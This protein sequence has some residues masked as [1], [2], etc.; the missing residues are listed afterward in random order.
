MSISEEQINNWAEPISETEAEKCSNAIR[1]IG[2]TIKEKFGNSVKIIHQ[3]SHKN[4]T[5]IRADS[6]VD[7]AVIYLDAYF[8]DIQHLDSVKQ[9]DYWNKLIPSDYNFAQFKNDVH[10]VLVDKFGLFDATRKNKC[11]RVNGNSYRVN[12]DVVPAF[13]SKR[14][15]NSGNV[16][17][18]GIG[19]IADNTGILK[20]SFPEHHYENGVKKNEETGNAFKAVVRI[21]KNLRNEMEE[22]NII[23]KGSI[24]SFFLE[25]LAYNV[26][27]NF[28]Q[29]KTYKEDVLSVMGKIW[30]DMRD[31]NTG[32]NYTEISHL[33]FLFGDSSRTTKQAEDFIFKAYNYLK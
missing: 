26:P 33:A 22:K 18:T 9:T 6:D 24:S 29:N 7:I 20:H 32:N 3:G 15:H 27:N 4:R 13:E 16:S 2:E 5:N 8:S 14:F 10:Q 12:A 31:V 30:A 19:F 23:P 17:H 28:F 21:L 11:V 25:N 1:I